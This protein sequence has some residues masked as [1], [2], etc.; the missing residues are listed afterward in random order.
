MMLTNLY[1]GSRAEWTVGME[2]QE[3]IR[4]ENDN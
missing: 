4:Y 3:V 2:H 1:S